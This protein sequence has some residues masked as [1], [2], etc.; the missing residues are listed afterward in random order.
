M[1]YF[2]IE[3]GNQCWSPVMLQ[4]INGESNFSGFLEMTYDEMKSSENLEEFVVATMEA[5]NK[6]S[7]TGD[8]QTM[9]TLVGEDDC[10]IWGIMMGSGENDDIRFSLIDWQKDGNHY[11]YES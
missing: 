8:D 7:G 1:R 3:R 10:F 9:V 11:R 5:T 6:V 4:S 2:A